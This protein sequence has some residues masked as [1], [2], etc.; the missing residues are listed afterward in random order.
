MP[1]GNRGG[2]RYT[3]NVRN[4]STIQ[5]TAS[6]Q[7]AQDTLQAIA[8]GESVSYSNFMALTDDEKADAI[9]LMIQQGIPN[10]LDDSDFQ[11]I[12]YY[13]EV[14]GKPQVV[15]DSALDAM[16]G[17]EMFRT[18]NSYYN[19]RTDVNYTAKEIY[20]Q[21][22]D[23]DYTMVS[24]RG[25]SAYGKGLYFAHG[26]TSSTSYR[27]SSAKSSL[28]MRGKLNSNAREITETSAIRG[29]QREISNGTKL[30][31]VL[32]K[33]DRANA[34]STYALAKGYNV[35]ND[36]YNDYYVILDRSAITMS[37]KTKAPRGT[38]W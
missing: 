37:S 33:M 1:K 17:Q 10:F 5:I 28:V 15:S 31:K 32:S 21:L 12:L 34:T 24:G 13:T 11:K 38:S 8:D 6:T 7:Q 20:N 23:G 35:I 30:G 26:Y 22:V 27:N 29:Y 4:G 36:G 19:P 3:V 9:A 25:G 14:D 18:V 2:R 16:S